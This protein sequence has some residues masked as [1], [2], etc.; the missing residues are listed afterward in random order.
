MMCG[1][2]SGISDFVYCVCVCVCCVHVCVCV[3]CARVSVCVCTCVSVSV[4]AHVCM[5]VC[6][7]VMNVMTIDNEMTHIKCELFTFSSK[8]CFFYY[9]VC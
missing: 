9:I 5:C 2:D 8:Y 1:V 3:V 4:C 6:K 7:C